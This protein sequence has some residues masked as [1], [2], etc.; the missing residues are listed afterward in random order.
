MK[1]ILR[2]IFPTV[3][4]LAFLGG[5]AMAQTGKI[6]TVDMR[7]LFD[8]YW[9]TKQADVALNDRKAELAKE[10]NSF[11][12][13]LKKD[14]DEYQKLLDTANDQAVSA[15]EREKRKQAA[16]DKD[17]QIKDSET[18]IVQFERQAQATLADQSQRMRANILNEIKTAVATEAKAAGCAMVIDGASDSINQT[19]VVLYNK[20]EN[21]L[22]AAVLA[23]LNAGAPLD[24]NKPSATTSTNSP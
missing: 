23:R 24:L 11:I 18:T 16:A 15:D 9:K 8:G 3:L 14:R 17:K 1:S 12:D 4:L 21:D 6:A 7:K 5:S 13:G 20:G 22:T 2:I 10:D 19:P